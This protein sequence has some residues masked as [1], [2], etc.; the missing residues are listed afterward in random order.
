MSSQLSRD[1]TSRTICKAAE[2]QTDGKVGNS[3]LSLHRQSQRPN[4]LA[5]SLRKYNSRGRTSLPERTF[6]VCEG[7]RYRAWPLSR[8]VIL[9]FETDTFLLS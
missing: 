9:N 3:R 8:R 4:I 5:N 6:P 1:E 2:Y 7:A